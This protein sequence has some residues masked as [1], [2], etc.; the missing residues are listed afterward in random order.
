ME[1]Q[2]ANSTTNSQM[3]DL[4]LNSPINA[5]DKLILEAA[6]IPIDTKVKAKSASQPLRRSMSLRSKQNKDI[7]HRRSRS[8]VREVAKNGADE[9]QTGLTV[10]PCPPLRGEEFYNIPEHIDNQMYVTRDSLYSNDVSFHQ[11]RPRPPQRTV[12]FLA[13]E[14]LPRKISFL[15]ERELC[16]RMTQKSEPSRQYDPR[17]QIHSDTNLYRHE[18]ASDLLQERYFHYAGQPC[19]SGA[20]TTDQGL[21]DQQHT[22]SF[23]SPAPIP[24]YSKDAQSPLLHPPEAT[25]R[26]E[27]PLPP[28]PYMSPPAHRSPPDLPLP[29]PPPVEIEMPP[30][31]AVPSM[32]AIPNYISCPNRVQ[33][34]RASSS[35]SIDSGYGRSSA[36]ESIKV[37]HGQSKGMNQPSSPQA[38]KELSNQYNS[39]PSRELEMDSNLQNMINHARQA[40]SPIEAFSW[41]TITNPIQGKGKKTVRIQIPEPVS[42]SH[43]SELLVTDQVKRE[44]N[45]DS[46]RRRQYRVGLTLFNQNPDIGIEYLLKKQ[47]LDF[48]PA[49]TAAFLLGRKGLSKRV[50]G[51]YLTNLQRPFNLAVLHCFIHGMD[52]T[53]LHLDIALRQL[54]EEVTLPGEA[55]KIEKI[56]EVF[57]KRYIQCNQMFVAGF[58]C[59]DT[60]F[61]LSYAIVLLNTDLHSRAVRSSRRMRREDFI[62]NLKGVDSGQDLD[63]EMLQGIYDRIRNTEFRVGSDHVTQVNKVEESITGKGR[64]ELAL[65]EPHRRLVCFCR[66]TEVMDIN[67]QEKKAGVHQRGVFLFNDVLVNTKTIVS[68]KKTQHQYRGTILLNEI[69]VAPFSSAHF[70]CGIQ[71]QDRL[72]GKVV[73]TFNARSHNDQQRFLSDLQESIAETVDFERAKMFMNSPEES[74]C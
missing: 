18:P 51:E 24:S 14:T 1:D 64:N 52:F 69:R 34:D 12:S 20:S 27:S 2:R 54:Q 44:D 30:P 38:F 59:P 11:E 35:S 74:L 10:P 7:G 71:L 53:G 28:P 68:K 8:V 32:V 73:L 9:F 36:M 41:T 61:V 66:L 13:H 4:R 50:I 62:R 37:E 55:Q 70:T 56:V 29:S 31:A 45:D 15:K 3:R 26:T 60:I 17:L 47:F 40:M 46:F 21:I 57:S 72:T 25:R 19:Q 49:A 42:S 22:R 16:L 23:S 5:I 33:S 43:P 48:S 58:R 6:G 63:L 67:R 65:A 39:S